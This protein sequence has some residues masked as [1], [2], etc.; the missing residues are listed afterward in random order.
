MRIQIWYLTNEVTLCKF[1]SVWRLPLL[2]FFSAI[3]MKWVVNKKN[4]LFEI[5]HK[6]TFHLD[7]AKFF[8]RF[9]DTEA[10]MLRSPLAPDILENRIRFYGHMNK[11]DYG[12]DVV[13][14]LLKL[15]INEVK[16]SVWWYL[17][18][19]QPFFTIIFMVWVFLRQMDGR[20]LV[21]CTYQ[22]C[23]NASSQL[24]LLSTSTHIRDRMNSFASKLISSQ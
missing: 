1:Y 20:V 23:S 5:V 21:I 14:G 2:W 12:D 6:I 17:G 10:W 15:T 22:A 4:Y 7:F 3:K 8:F 13:I 18:R 11:K 16:K 9:S 24:S 19:R